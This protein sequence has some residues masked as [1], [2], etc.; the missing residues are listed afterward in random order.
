MAPLQAKT[1]QPEITG[2][3]WVMRDPNPCRQYPRSGHAEDRRPQ[4]ISATF[5]GIGDL[6]PPWQGPS[7]FRRACQPAAVQSADNPLAYGAGSFYL[8]L[9]QWACALLV[10]SAISSA[11]QNLSFPVGL[12]EGQTSSDRLVLGRPIGAERDA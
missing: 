5:R 2:A 6:P 7:L 10:I 9:S 11:N 3:R 12:P 1:G 8:D 4:W